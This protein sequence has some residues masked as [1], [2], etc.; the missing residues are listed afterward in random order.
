[1]QLK[2]M[3]FAKGC[4]E[5]FVNHVEAI[6]NQSTRLYRELMTNLTSYLDPLSTNRRIAISMMRHRKPIDPIVFTKKYHEFPQFS[7]EYYL[8]II[9]RWWGGY[10]PSNLDE[11]IG[12]IS[13]LNMSMIAYV[14]DTYDFYRTSIDW[15]K[16]VSDDL[17]TFS[18]YKRVWQLV[19]TLWNRYDD[20][21]EAIMAYKT[22]AWQWQWNPRVDI[23]GFT[24]TPVINARWVLRDISFENGSFQCP[25][26]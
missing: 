14:D 3:V 10:Y 20:I 24:D 23:T 7:D 16:K 1:M 22:G 26:Q 4:L 17:Y 2:R 6:S 15:S 13:Y 25:M 11:V 12:H 18:F 5:H 21:E 19:K 8:N 9:N